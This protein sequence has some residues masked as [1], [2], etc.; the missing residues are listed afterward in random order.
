MKYHKPGE[1]FTT[2]DGYEFLA[3]GDKGKGCY[4]CIGYEHNDICHML[5]AGCGGGDGGIAWVPLNDLAKTL[6]VVI[7]LEGK[8]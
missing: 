7:K 2:E 1:T 5:P 3:K 4:L 6:Y 8:P